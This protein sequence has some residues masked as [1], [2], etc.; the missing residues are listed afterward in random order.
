MSN[1]A[2]LWLT[3]ENGSPVIGGSLVSGRVGA[4]E[5][6]S[7]THNVQVP[8]DSNTGRLTGTRVHSPLSFQKEFDKVTPLL[9][10][11]LSQG[12]TMKSATFKMYQIL[13]AGIESEYFNIILE[14]VK[15]TSITPNLYQGGQT[16]THFETIQMRYEAIT[17]KCCEGNIIFKDSW[18]N[19]WVA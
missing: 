5:L 4:I 11:G 7:L 15:I 19:R 1:P 10:K 14:N 16:G 18:N 13:D 6:K 17:W 8:T 9:Y 3:D 12:L 2:Y